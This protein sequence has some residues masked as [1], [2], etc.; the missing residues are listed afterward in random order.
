MASPA[1]LAVDLGAES[2]RV[3]VGKLDDG[4]LALHEAHRFLHHPVDLPSGLHWDLT[5]LWHNILEGL[6]LGCAWCGEHEL[7]PV[8]IG[9]DTWG[10]DFALLDRA[11][12]F[13]HMPHAYRDPRNAAAYEKTIQ[14]LG[15]KKIYDATGI[16]FMVFNSLYQ[17]VAAHDAD[18]HIFERA[19]TLLFI[20][21]LL[22]NWLTGIKCNE[23]TVASTSQM[24]DPQSGDW[25][26]H[27]IEDAQLPTHI[28][29][30]IVQPGSVL[31]PLLPRVAKQIGATENTCVILPAAHDTASAIA[32]VPVDESRGRWCYLSSGT[33]SLLGAE[34]DKPVLTDAARE[35]SFTNEAGVMG[36]IRFLKNIAGLWLVQEIKR[37]LER[38]GESYDYPTL[39]KL[40][41]EAKPFATLFDTTHAPF[42]QPGDMRQ[43]MAE[44]AEKTGQAIPQTPGQF[45]RAALESLALT[46][47]QTL[48]T[49]ENILGTTYDVMHIVG[50]GGKNELLNQMTADA[51]GRPVIVGPG[52]ATAIGNLMLQA[53]GADEVADLSAARKIIATSF[54]PV[55][56]TP[57]GTSAWDT[58]WIRFEKLISQ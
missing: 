5:G 51:I 56:V 42:A 13:V 45:I 48:N 39:T 58:A 38:A 50:G 36:T 55:T 32:A 1:F 26:T 28:L 2:G 31:G 20:P 19:Q 49:L 22:H 44:Y 29:G 10:V 57:Q 21:D 7:R 40:A 30:E 41:A 9:V 4:R 14:A 43:K 47:R 23:A 35:A 17:L 16:Q 27:L 24:V 15:K 46:Y 3:I 6:R 54:K 33:W 11:G 18:E 12:E 53:I 37:D 25:A 52:E 8:S 34:I